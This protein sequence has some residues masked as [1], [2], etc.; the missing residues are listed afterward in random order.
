MG[1]AVAAERVLRWSASW[2]LSLAGPSRSRVRC[3]SAWR[4]FVYRS[5]LHPETREAVVVRYRLIESF[6]D[7]QDATSAAPAAAGGC[8]RFHGL[9]GSGGA[10]VPH[11]D[12]SG[13]VSR[14]P[15]VIRHLETEPRFGAGTE[16]LRQSDG[17]LDRDPRFLVDELGQCLACH[18]QAPGR[19][20]HREAKRLETLPADDAARWGGSCM[21]I[22][23]APYGPQW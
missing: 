9:L 21:A 6:Y 19:V 7:R 8:A 13:T 11:F 2:S 22:G 1:A 14:L 17:H 18:A 23:I 12:L 16:G 3:Y 10:K 15:Q 5:I 20:G 4:D